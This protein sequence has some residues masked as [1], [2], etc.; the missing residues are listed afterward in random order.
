M[1]SRI[2]NR[3]KPQ[4]ANKKNNVMDNYQTPDFDPN[5]FGTDDRIR[6]LEAKMAFL[7]D[8]ASELRRI[9][10]F[11]AAEKLDQIM[12]VTQSR[13]SFDHQ[14][15]S[16]PEGHA[17]LSNEDWKKGVADTICKFSDLPPEWFQGKKVMDAGCGQGR[18]T[19]GF[20][21]LGVGSCD[22][23]DISEA[24]IER[25]TAI[26]KNAG[27]HFRVHRLNVLEPLPF[28]QDYDMVWCFGMLHHTGDTY[29]GFNNLA[30]LVKPGGYFFVMLYGEPRPN[31]LGDYQYYHEIFKMRSALRALPF[32]E[33]IAAIEKKY[34]NELLH[35]Y[36]DAISP[37]INDLYR[38]DEVVSW[39]Q[40][41]GYD[42]I[43][44]TLLEH[45]NHHVIAMKKG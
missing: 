19:Y 22:S 23:F 17:M 37:D 26:A 31:D 11:L 2:F 24:G 28:E 45:P 29:T 14:W 38:W 21:K 36:F 8:E 30:R 5:A 25:T 43:K 18:W 10:R 4:I 27:D 1:L 3:H 39:Y 9:I 40:A 32:D 7:Q 16:L 15:R 13:A 12:A 33:K 41:C 6:F 20:S 44:R 35:G 42:N 34:G